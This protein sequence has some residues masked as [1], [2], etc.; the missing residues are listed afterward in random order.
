MGELSTA[1]RKSLP[2]GSAS[3]YWTI[4]SIRKYGNY[5][6][7]PKDFYI[8]Y[9]KNVGYNEFFLPSYSWLKK[10]EKNLKVD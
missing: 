7:K 4:K 1:V 6:K 2:Q 10:N 5:L 8:V 9:F 3:E